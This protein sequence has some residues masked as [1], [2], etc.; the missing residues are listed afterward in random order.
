MRSSRA[1]IW[2]A[3]LTVVVVVC[4]LIPPHV[5][6]QTSNVSLLQDVAIGCLGALPESVQDVRLDAPDEMPYLR[7]AL[8]DAWQENGH[9]VYV[10]G[11]L[12]AAARVHYAVEEAAVRYERAGNG[13]ARDIRLSLRFTITASDGR[14]LIDDRCTGRRTDVIPRDRIDLVEDAA[15]PETQGEPPEGGWFRR[16][17][18]PAVVTTATAIAV[19]LFFS[20]R[21]EG[22]GGS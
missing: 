9:A 5:A 3:A 12:S 2:L 4:G 8:V 21:S 17:L 15:Y 22:G 6:A 11:D 1:G 18:E 20:L 19:F 10:D 14:V 16:I 7:S 13:I